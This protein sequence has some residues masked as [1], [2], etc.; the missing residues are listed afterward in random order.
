MTTRS[1][2]PMRIDFAGGWTDVSDFVDDE[3]GIVVNAA[4]NLFARVEVSLGGRTIRLVAEDLGQRQV[5][6]DLGDITYNGPLLLHKAAL[7]MMPVTGGIELI[8]RSDAPLGSGLGGSGA[9]DVALL[10]ALARVRRERFEARELAELAFRLESRELGLQGGRQDQYAAALGGFNRLDFSTTGVRAQRL[11]LSADAGRELGLCVVLIYTGQTHFSSKTHDRVWNSYR[12]S[13]AE[14]TSALHTIRDVADAAHGALKTGNY[15]RL[16]DL[17]D[18]NWRQQQRLDPTIA[19]SKMRE[20]EHAVRAVGA[21]GV[22]ATG[23]GAGGCLAAFT[24]PADRAAI[25]ASAR[26]CGGEI[27]EFEFCTDGVEIVET[28]DAASHS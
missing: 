13:D 6:R 23:A 14:V 3:G 21:W 1:R 2:A 8:S 22:K 16:A 10:A 19:T 11:E 17:V 24:D 20:I 15:R 4:I 28:E 7:T 5:F 27:L 25:E 18:E 26:A 9:L 12:A